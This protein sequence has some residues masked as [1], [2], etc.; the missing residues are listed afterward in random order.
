[1]IWTPGP[2]D[3]EGGTPIGHE[4]V[5]GGVRWKVALSTGTPRLAIRTPGCPV[6]AELEVSSTPPAEAAAIEAVR[7]RYAEARALYRADRL[8]AAIEG[9]EAAAGEA[10]AI[11]MASLGV[12]AAAAGAFVAAVHRADMARARRS[13]DRAERLAAGVP[14]LA[15]RVRY[16]EGQ[17]ASRAGD[18]RS[19]LAHFREARGPLERLGHPHAFFVAERRGVVLG[20]IGRYAE[21]EALLEGLLRETRDPCQQA[22]VMN[23]LG[24]VRSQQGRP[25]GTWLA[26]AV[27]IYETTCANPRSLRNARLSLAEAM[28]AEGRPSEA[29]AVVE[30]L[31]VRTSSSASIVVPALELRGRIA[32]ATGDAAGALEA[33]DALVPLARA[34]GAGRQVHGG[35]VGR[36]RA[37]AA[38]GRPEAALEL[39]DAAEAAFD[40]QL[41]SVPLGEGLAQFA[42]SHAG[43]ERLQL[44]LLVGL[45]RLDEAV[46]ALRRRRSRALAR[47]VR[48]MRL[49]VLDPDT[50]EAWARAAFDYR[51]ARTALD[52]IADADW[53]RP[54]A[55]RAAAEARRTEARARLAAAVDGAERALGLGRLTLGPRP[56]DAPLLAIGEGTR[57]WVALLA[58]SRGIELVRRPT[59]DRGGE[60][61]TLAAVIEQ[62][63][64]RLTEQPR[65]RVLLG[66]AG[67]E[68]ELAALPLGDGAL[69][70][71]LALEYVVDLPPATSATSA[72]SLV[73]GD[74]EDNLAAARAEAIAVDRRL[75]AAELRLGAEASRAALRARLPDVGWLHYAGHGRFEG[76]DGI[77]SALPLGDGSITA[78]DLLAI[79]RVPARVVLT[80]CETTR[81]ATGSGLGLGTAFLV[82]GARE[83][84]GASRRVAD[85]S[86]R[87]I[88][89][90]LYV[91]GRPADLAEALRRAQ[92]VER[93]RDPG[94]DWA[95]FRVLARMPGTTLS[96]APSGPRAR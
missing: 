81:A 82:A 52:E 19:A 96:R 62:L 13:L 25:S 83:V 38:L 2:V 29:L 63:A 39:L 89:E 46:D 48:P 59:P 1:M 57:G 67:D 69:L 4:P 65:L 45:G 9:Y 18:L 12:S 11:G 32:L 64:P 94:S 60:A 20:H 42:P 77:W 6:A 80:G 79:R 17:Q 37:L 61:A 71:R 5:A 87:G 85:A 51:S 90:G 41:A 76:G 23:D 88:G 47:H 28:L 22:L 74:P 72:T 33:F 49:D 16:Y 95:A 3:F 40:L 93:S 73:I 43:A 35:L 21:A 58:D 78:A 31:G 86:A 56:T 50:R 68:V 66:G 27:G 84:L 36:G 8:D 34:A 7:A 14:V 30:A 26:Q 92:L 24:W 10:E 91:D 53:S 44:E 54:V 55:E 15:A 70:D 75:D